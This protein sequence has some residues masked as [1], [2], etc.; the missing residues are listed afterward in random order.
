MTG[1]Q[2]CALPISP[3]APSLNPVTGNGGEGPDT[4]TDSERSAGFSLSGSAEANSAININW[5][6]ASF[7]TSSDSSGQW[8]LA[9]SSG[10]IPSA[11]ST[12]LSVTS[13]DSAGNTSEATSRTVTILPAPPA[14]SQAAVAI[15]NITTDSGVIGDFITNDTTLLV[16]G[17]NGNL[18]AGEKV[19]ISVD[20][21]NWF[22][23]TA[24]SATS[25][26]YDDTATTRASSFS[27]R[28]RVINSSSVVGN[29]TSQLITIDTVA[30]IGRAHV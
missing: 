17:T 22:D 5:N 29:T 26:S 20:G 18:A 28:A 10:A 1:V 6:G 19:Q 30:Q 9:F 7:A 21:V 13:T 11:G 3:V 24:T 8:S 12:S 4:V 27:Y 23:T 25:W 15:T 2:T 16:A 14:G